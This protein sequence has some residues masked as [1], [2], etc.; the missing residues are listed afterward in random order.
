[1]KILMV[2]VNYKYSSTGKIV[3]DLSVQLKKNGHQVETCFGRGK[4]V[5][6][7]GVVRVATSTEVVVHA[8]LSRIS[9]LVDGFSPL[10][11]KRLIAQVEEFR[12]DVVHLHELHGYY[13]NISEFVKFLKEKKISVVWT[14]HCEFMYTGR[15]GHANECEKWK[16]TCYDCPQLSE[17][18]R[19]LFFDFS[20][21]MHDEKKALFQNFYNL[22]IVTPSSW[23]AKRVSQSFLKN[24]RIEV[25]YN[26]IDTDVFKPTDHEYLRGR[27]GL[28]SERIFLAVAPNLMSEIKGGSWIVELAKKF[29]R[30]D[31]TFI[32][33][34]IADVDQSWPD[35]LIALPLLKDQRELAAYYSIADLTLLPS[36]KETFSLVTVESL[37]CGTPVL[38]FDSGAP[39]EVAPKG[40][41]HFV[42]YGDLDSLSR[43]LEEFLDGELVFHSK[44]ACVEFSSSNYSKEKMFEGY[45][46]LYED[47]YVDGVRK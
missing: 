22:I 47:E 30:V 13:V 26:G 46:S 6:E 29:L 44:E 25:V 14:F 15:C 18:P 7:V 28:T 21:K 43:S 27:H 45:M 5:E 1:M 17:Y 40:Y 34:G 35:N 24:K 3:H 36:R 19:S 38:G 11:T 16:E 32:L 39:V 41:G 23:L 31:I 8:V 20:Q 2:D 33:I 10:A 37:A 12:P 9:G 4:V 42:K